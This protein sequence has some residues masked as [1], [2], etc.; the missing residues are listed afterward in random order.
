MN[1][2][3]RVLAV[4][5]CSLFLAASLPAQD[6]NKPLPFRTA[7]EL[8]LKNSA[9]SGVGRADLERARA[10]VTE[11]RDPFLPSMTVGAVLGYSNGF[12]LSLE[13][14]APSLFN[15]NIQGMLVNY[16]QHQYIK[17]AKSDAEAAAAQNADRRHDVIMEAALDYIQLDLLASSLT[18]QKE[19]QAAAA[20]FQDITS[21]RIQ[22][23]LDSPV[24]LTRAKLV[25]ART[26][27]DIARSQ[28]AADQLRLR[29]SQLTGLPAASIQTATETIPPLPTI[30]QDDDLAGE[31]AARNPLIKVAEEAA[32]AKEF[33]AKAERKQLYPTVDLAGQYAVLARYNNYDKFFQPGSFQ[34]NNLSIGVVVRFPLFN[35]T[36]RS[37]ANV[38]EFDALKARQETRTVK[39]QV[40]AD[41]RRLQ[42]S[43]EQLMAARD[44]AQLEHELAESD[45]ETAHAKIE[46]GAASLKDEQNARVA[47]HERYTA[48]LSSS[49][50]LDKAQVQLL[51]ETGDLENWALGPRR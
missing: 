47:E 26:R 48:Y 49:F 1:S 7:I 2:R 50:D 15:V 32:L 30:S 21:Q 5:L 13:G 16:A 33:R 8:A 4:V 14:S 36:L 18:V 27:F 28:T 38:A 43:V 37:A 17:A 22:A 45:I 3:V 39:E 9:A 41:T 42:R 31:A 20:K 34:R 40:S 29:L 19:Q 35:Q 25:V 51:R 23:G 24:E 44:V 11:T 10:T 46:S 12:P 6:N